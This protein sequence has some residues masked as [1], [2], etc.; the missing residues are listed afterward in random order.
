MPD[1]I[2]CRESDPNRGEKLLIVEWLDEECGRPS[3]QS[4]RSNQGIILSGEDD[5]ASRRRNFPEPRLHFEAVHDWHPDINHCN[6]G[7]MSLGIKQKFFGIAKLFDAPVGGG[8]QTTYPF[9]HGGIV[10]EQTDWSSGGVKQNRPR[11]SRELPSRN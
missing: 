10:V 9:Q 4:C 8:K 2:H 1:L 6:R 11:I 7:A 3:A 5:D